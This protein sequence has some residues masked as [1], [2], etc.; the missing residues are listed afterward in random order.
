MI[1]DAMRE[2]NW[3]W[4]WKETERHLVGGDGGVMFKG[5]GYRVEERGR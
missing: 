5:V 3:E 4:I 1:N 2:K